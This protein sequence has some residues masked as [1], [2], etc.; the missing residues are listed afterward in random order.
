[1]S[2]TGLILNVAIRDYYR[3]FK[4]KYI[5]IVWLNMRMHQIVNNDAVIF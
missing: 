3:Q 2:N 1:M 5:D 4:R